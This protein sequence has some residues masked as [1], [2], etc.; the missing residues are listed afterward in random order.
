MKIIHSI[1]ILIFLGIWNNAFADYPLVGYRFLADPGAIVYNGRVYVYCS[2]DDENDDDSY[3]MSSIVCVSSSDLKN[4]TD[5]GVVFDVPRDASWSG[6]SW[7]PSPS[8]RNGKFYLYFGNGGSAIGVAVS[9][10]PTGP[11]KDPVGRGFVTGS[12]PGVQPFNGW[13]FDPMTFIDDDGQ[14]YMYFGGNGDGNMRVIKLNNDMISTSGSAGKFTVPNF[15]EASWMHKH[16]GK[17]YFSYSTNPSAG[18]RIDYM[19]S[20]NPMSGFTYGGVLSPQ[21]P[22]N[23]N[24]NHH[25]NIFFNGQW[26]QIYHN[27]IVASQTGVGMAYHRN[28]AI[29]AFSH[30]QDGTIIQMVNTVNGVKQ[31]KYLD[32]YVRVEAETM[33]DYKGIETEVCSAGG[34]NLAYI[35][36]SD[37]VMIE[38]VDFGS[39]GAGRFSASVASNKAGGTIEIR[40][41]SATGTLIGTLQVPNTGGFKSWQTVNSTVNQTTGVHNVYLVFK[42]SGT[43]LFNV[44]HWSFSSSVPSVIITSPKSTDVLFTG[45]EITIS[46]TALAQSGTIASVEFF[47][48]GKSIGVDIAA[49]YSIKYTPAASGSH[50]ITATVTDSQGYKSSSEISLSVNVPQGPYKGT[51]WSIPGMIEAEHYD[52]GGEGFAFHEANTNGNEGLAA[53]RN[54]EVDVETTMDVS[55]SYNV[56]YILSGEWLEYTVNVTATDKYDLN[57]RV[58]AD[59]SGRTFHLEMDNVDITGDIIVP[60]TGG[61]QKWET[62]TVPGIDL[63]SGQKIMRIV[64]E[65]DYMNLNWVEFKNTV[66]TGLEDTQKEITA[67]YPNPFNDK[68]YCNI[69]GEYVYELLNMEGVVLEDGSTAGEINIQKNYPKGMYILK[70][71]QNNLVKVL[72]VFKE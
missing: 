24:N 26:Y 43:S 33:S 42:G 68:I 19:V 53:L 23:N 29:D 18:M 39:S 22:T 36:N 72:K 2:N 40:L 71:K 50:G 67:I 59:G 58:A 60:N 45:T 64:F 37:W 13:L 21:P 28:L 17:Y 27:R 20:N 7:A 55:G 9:D 32:P 62:I 65:S 63:T 14:A 48:D 15:F 4:W 12:T 34:M 16:N 52:V 70:I 47:Y 1:L 35:D 56:G 10:S 69:P 3:D 30:R 46:A 61:W 11:F 41:G 5:H 25:A 44:D 8:Y 66:I 54:D 38:G 49:P 51:P 57:L 6:L 31:V